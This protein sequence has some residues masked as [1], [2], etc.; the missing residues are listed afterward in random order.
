MCD[1]C[2]LPC[3]KAVF[4]VRNIVH[5]RFWTIRPWSM[6]GEESGAEY[7]SYPVSIV[8]RIRLLL[9]QCWQVTSCW[10]YIDN[11]DDARHRC[12]R[13][14]PLFHVRIILPMTGDVKWNWTFFRCNRICWIWR[15]YYEVYYYWR[16]II[17]GNVNEPFLKSVILSELRIQV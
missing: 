8:G 13:T 11:N 2:G 17:M 7:Y 6:V 14:W 3:S 5:Y 16:E 12:V 1:S 4:T 10:W 9:A 15:L